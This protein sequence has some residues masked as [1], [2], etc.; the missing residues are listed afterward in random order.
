MRQVL[1]VPALS[2]RATTT[3]VSTSILHVLPSAIMI[4]LTKDRTNHAS[5]DVGAWDRLL[6]LFVPEMD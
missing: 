6:G 4:G 1:Q 5:G 3:T 2:R